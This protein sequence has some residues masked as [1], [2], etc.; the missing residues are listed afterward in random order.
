MQIGPDAQEIARTSAALVRRQMQT[1]GWEMSL[2]TECVRISPQ[3]ET[4]CCTFHLLPLKEMTM[5]SRSPFSL[6]GMY[7]VKCSILSIKASDTEWGPES[8]RVS[9]AGPRL[10]SKLLCL[11]GLMTQEIHA[12]WS[13]YGNQQCSMKPLTCSSREVKVRTLSFRSKAL[14]S[15]TNNNFLFEKWLLAFN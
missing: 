4:C 13:F 3:C 9:G 2:S 8:S 10:Q 1:R 6:E 11:L 14:P 15:F 12:A 5:P 7:Q